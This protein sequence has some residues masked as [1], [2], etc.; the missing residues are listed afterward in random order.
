MHWGRVRVRAPRGPHTL[1]LT[2][3]D[4][5]IADWVRYY[6]TRRDN[7]GLKEVPGV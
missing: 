5:A 2:T 7:P 1:P 4:Q 3:R 6:M